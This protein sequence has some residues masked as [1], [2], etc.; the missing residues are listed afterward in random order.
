VYRRDANSGLIGISK[1]GT[2]SVRRSVSRGESHGS[3]GSR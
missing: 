1:H 3:P 2:A